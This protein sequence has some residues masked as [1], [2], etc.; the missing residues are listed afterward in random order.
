MGQLDHK[1]VARTPWHVARRRHDGV[2]E[3]CSGIY[4]SDVCVCDANTIYS[5]LGKGFRSVDVLTDV[6]LYIY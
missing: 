2:F 5:N 1:L 4:S 3:N 6:L